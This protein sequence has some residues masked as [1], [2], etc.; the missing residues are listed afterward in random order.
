MIARI[1]KR[2]AM[3]LIVVVA[4]SLWTFVICYPNPYVFIRNL[5]RYARF[6]VDPS[7]IF[8]AWLDFV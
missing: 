3:V 2:W 5:V 8:N 7:V 4:L 1:E 6:P